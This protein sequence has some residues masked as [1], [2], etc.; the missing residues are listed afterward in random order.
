MTPEEQRRLG[1]RR[2]TL[3]YQK[4]HIKEGKKIKVY[5]KVQN[6]MVK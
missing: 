6:K 3:W 2:N 5:G 4:K 1:L